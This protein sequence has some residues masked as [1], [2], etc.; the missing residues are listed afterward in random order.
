MLCINSSSLLDSRCR[1]ASDSIGSRPSFTLVMCVSLSG[2]N[3]MV[4]LQAKYRPPR[5]ILWEFIPAHEWPGDF[6][7]F[8]KS[9]G[10][11][12]ILRSGELPRARMLNA[13]LADHAAKGQESYWALK[14]L[15]PFPAVVTRL[16]GLLATDDYDMHRLV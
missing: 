10:S 1:D 15:P 3:A 12:T 6:L 5:C 9:T 13:H 4:C 2:N 11:V 16:L 8:R 7:F 14:G